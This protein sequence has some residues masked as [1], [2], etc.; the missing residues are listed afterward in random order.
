MNKFKK[1]SFMVTVAQ[2]YGSW[3]YGG[4]TIRW[5]TVIVTQ[6]P[7]KVQ[8]FKQNSYPISDRVILQINQSFIELTPDENQMS[9]PLEA[10]TDLRRCHSWLRKTTHTGSIE[11]LLASPA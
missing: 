3:L 11:V 6:L 7:L 10:E 1:F 4:S 8:K 9:V 5:V 2:K